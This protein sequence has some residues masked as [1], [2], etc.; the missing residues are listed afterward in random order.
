MAYT[1]FPYLFVPDVDSH[2]LEMRE[3][4]IFSDY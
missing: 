1:R 3:N 4:T 2:L